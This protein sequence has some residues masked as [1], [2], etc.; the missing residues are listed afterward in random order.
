LSVTGQSR[1]APILASTVR[2]IYNQW[3]GIEIKFPPPAAGPVLT[4]GNHG[5]GY[6][7][8]TKM[9]LIKIE[10][11]NTYKNWLGVL[12]SWLGG[13]FFGDRMTC[14]GQF[15]RGHAWPFAQTLV[16]GISRPKSCFDF[17]LC[18]NRSYDEPFSV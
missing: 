12:N 16:S 6:Q 3:K 4:S 5:F 7:E 2:I 17:D 15:A 9:F 11:T 1:I 8:N 10:I 13:W 18:S 14:R